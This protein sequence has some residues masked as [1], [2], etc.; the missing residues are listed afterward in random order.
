MTKAD[1]ISKMLFCTEI[2]PPLSMQEINEF[3]DCEIQDNPV[4]EIYENLKYIEEKRKAW[5]KT[6]YPTKKRI[7]EELKK[8]NREIEDW[9]ERKRNK[10][11]YIAPYEIERCLEKKRK[12][13]ARLK[14]KIPKGPNKDIELAKQVPITNF[15]EFNGAGF[16]KC[17]WHE[18]KTASL[19]LLPTQNAVWCFSC[20]K[21]FDVID[22]VMAYQKI[23]F[24]HALKYILG[25]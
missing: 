17:L 19:H 1:L 15:A 24:N 23:D 10:T 2:T 7:S 9:M 12:L 20:C 18:E 3:V 21:R 11:S 6:D 5:E 25:Q 14:I 22:Y 13:Q 4:I 16:T 8:T